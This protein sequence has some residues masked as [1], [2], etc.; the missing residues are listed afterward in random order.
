MKWNGQSSNVQS[1]LFDRFLSFTFP[2]H[3]GWEGNMIGQNDQISK[4]K[5]ILLLGLSHIVVLEGTM[6]WHSC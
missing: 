3:R 4:E 1:V 5:S 2:P 6:K